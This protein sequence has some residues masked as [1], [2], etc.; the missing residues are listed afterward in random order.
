MQEEKTPVY[1]LPFY[2]LSPILCPTLGG[3]LDLPLSVHS[4][5][6]SLLCSR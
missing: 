6:R 3:H 4:S 1:K 5:A 2:V